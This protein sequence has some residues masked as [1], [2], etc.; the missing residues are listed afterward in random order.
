LFASG[1]SMLLY[2]FTSATINGLCHW[3]GYK[4]FN[5]TAGNLQ[6]VAF[7]SGGE[8]L[9]NNHHA[10]PA[11]PKLSMRKFEFDPAWPFI[12]ILSWI[13]LCAPAKTVSLDKP[14][15]KTIEA[16]LVKNEEVAD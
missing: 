7:I 5:N 8:G 10:F 1:L 4:N 2:V 15:H 6:S 12:K 16:R 14:L 3:A 11:C 9:H 13:K